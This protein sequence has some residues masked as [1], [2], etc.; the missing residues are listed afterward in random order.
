MKRNYDSISHY[1][2]SDKA[3]FSKL[4]NM[5]EKYES[6]VKNLTYENEALKKENLEQKDVIR[7]L[8]DKLSDTEKKLD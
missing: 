4:K 1:S 7:E 5:K 6:M 8:A 3:E 2:A